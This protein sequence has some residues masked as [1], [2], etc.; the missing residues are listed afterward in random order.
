MGRSSRGWRLH[1]EVK[2][3][4]GSVFPTL[5][6]RWD[7]IKEWAE[8]LE[9]CVNSTVQY[10]MLQRQ[11]FLLA[12]FQWILSF[13]LPSSLWDSVLG[14][15]A[16]GLELILNDLG[17]SYPEF[18]LP[19]LLFDCLLLPCLKLNAGPFLARYFLIQIPISLSLPHGT[20]ITRWW[21]ISSSG[22]LAYFFAFISH[23]W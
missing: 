8:G 5:Q 21:Y 18:K 10:H 3:L 6:V 2:P 9:M 13:E 16:Y 14:Q 20:S 1:W 4:P 23:I 15:H 17:A 11:P 12:P 19:L 22:V 7:L